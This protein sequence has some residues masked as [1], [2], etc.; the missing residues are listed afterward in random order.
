MDKVMWRSS[1]VTAIASSGVLSRIAT[2]ASSMGSGRSRALVR[3]SDD[4]HGP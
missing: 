3:E 2:P 4:V 1:L